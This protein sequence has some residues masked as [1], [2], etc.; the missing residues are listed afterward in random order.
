M[1]AKYSK[2]NKISK[3]VHNWVCYIERFLLEYRENYSNLSQQ[4][5]TTK[6][7]KQ[8]SKQIHVF[9]VKSEKTRKPSR[10]YLEAWIYFTPIT[11]GT[12]AKPRQIRITLDTEVKNCSIASFNWNNNFKGISDWRS[13]KENKKNTRH[14]HH[15]YHHSLELPFCPWWIVGY[16]L[17]FDFAFISCRAPFC[18]LLKT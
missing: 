13:T 2:W 14:Y 1:K 16:L 15:Q 10:D 9:G 6:W 5:K 12:K 3:P 11:E 18:T 7:T 17:L 4:R 8:D